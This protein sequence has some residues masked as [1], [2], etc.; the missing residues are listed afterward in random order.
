VKC[1]GMPPGGAGVP[2][3]KD[4]ALQDL[5]RAAR[6]GAEVGADLV[7]VPYLGPT[8][9]FREVVSVCPVPLIAIG[10]GKK[11]KEKDFLQMV[12]EV[13]EAGAFGVSVGR[14]IFQHKKPGNMIKAVSQIVHKGFAVSTAMEAL[15]EDPIESSVF[16]SS[17]IW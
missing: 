5:M 16:G 13:M 6:I 15:K 9:A 8:A 11:A 4:K 14:N 2:K 12:H 7:R 3:D 17:V 1:P 10:G